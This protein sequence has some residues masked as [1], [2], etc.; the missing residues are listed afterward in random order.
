ML[1][2]LKSDN[3]VIISGLFKKILV[4]FFLGLLAWAYQAIQPPPPRICGSA[5]GPPVTAPRVKLSDGRHLAYI[6]YGV[7]KNEAKHKIIYVHGLDSCRHDAVI[8]T[9]LSPVRIL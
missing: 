5:D 6:E 7:P 4:A 9:Q 2:V 8:A 1:Y 3:H